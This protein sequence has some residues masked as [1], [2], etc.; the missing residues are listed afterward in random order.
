[1]RKRRRVGSNARRKRFGESGVVEI[2]RMRKGRHGYEEG[3]DTERVKMK[4]DL[5]VEFGERKEA[6]QIQNLGKK[7]VEYFEFV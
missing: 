1:M 2:Q 5:G 6:I 7:K 4:R 3:G